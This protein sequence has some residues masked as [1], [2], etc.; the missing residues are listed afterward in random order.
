MS[1]IFQRFTEAYGASLT[2]HLVLC[3][4]QKNHKYRSRDREVGSKEAL[5]I[6]THAELLCSV[7]CD[8]TSVYFFILTK[9]SYC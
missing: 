8:S 2:P 4:Y 1:Y 5:F 3:D 7:N 9:S 6:H